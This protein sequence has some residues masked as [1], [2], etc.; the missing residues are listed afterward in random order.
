M[1]EDHL[2]II[3]HFPSTEQNYDCSIFSREVTGNSGNYVYLY[4]SNNYDLTYTSIGDK[5]FCHIE[6]SDY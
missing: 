4:V 5:I 3:I 2:P 1:T 6:Q